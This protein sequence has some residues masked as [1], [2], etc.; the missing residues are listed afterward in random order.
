MLQKAGKSRDKYLD[1]FV[2]LQD[3]VDVGSEPNHITRPTVPTEH[4]RETDHLPLFPSRRTVG[5][6]PLFQPRM[7][8]PLPTTNVIIYQHR[9]NPH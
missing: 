1:I 2:C 6:P 5:Y 7:S 4:Q 3:Q 9:V 8:L